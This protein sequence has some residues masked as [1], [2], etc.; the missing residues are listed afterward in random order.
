M[1]APISFEFR[2]IQAL[3]PHTVNQIAAGEVVER[4]ASALKE[5]LENAIDAGSTRIEIELIDAGRTRIRV[6]DN[7]SGIP[8]EDL[9]LALQRHA[10]SKIRSVTDLSRVGTLGFRGEALPSIASVS[11]LT[12]RSGTDGSV[13]AG[14][15][16]E[17][18]TITPL[19][20]EPGPM[21]TEV[22]VEELF[23]N[24]PARLKFLR[25]DATELSLCVEM[26]Q[27]LA[28]AYPGVA[29]RLEHNGSELVRTMGEG[30]VLEALAS[31][32]GRELVRGLAEIDHFENGVR[33]R[34][35]VSPPHLTRSN[36][37]MQ[38]FFVN[39]RATRTR[40]IGTAL[41]VAFRLITPERRFPVAALFLDV[42]PARVD[43]NVSPTK[44]EV[45]FQHEV[46]VT[47]AVRHGIR[48]ALLRCGMNPDAGA[49]LKANEALQRETP[50]N[51]PMLTLFGLAR[52]PVG[53][54]GW[55]NSAPLPHPPPLEPNL[56]GDSPTAIPTGGRAYE[57][58]LEGLRIIGQSMNTFI[59]AE[60]HQGLLVVDQHVA[61]ER[62]LY[63]RFRRSLGRVP[64]ERQAL[65]MPETLHFESRQAV[66]LEEHREE[67]A[68]LG[69]ELDPFGAGSFLL[70]SAPAALRGRDPVKILRE[71]VEQMVEGGSGCV[72]PARDAV[73]IMAACK[74]AVKAGDPLSH[75]EMEKLLLDLGETENPYLCPHGRPITL[76]L[77][78]GDL[79]RR[80]KRH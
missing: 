12:L 49:I 2:R 57:S 19:L 61:H 14:V 54:E 79:E 56:D 22:L 4:P 74:M 51:D 47:D 59:I 30:N 33:V 10:T 64:V 55:T 20:P 21:G 23:Y 8:A 11:R 66:L 58:L 7:G 73:W 15:Q 60:N 77:G 5:L 76:V 48:E 71:V 37:S 70:R 45:K 78:R 32:W 44:M 34:G 3:D 25:S 13:R 6:R 39:Q 36:R 38:W 42:D 53:S 62:I 75:A 16:V 29:V 17:S 1:A 72:A 40:S 46:Q 50:A 27:R 43:C 68:Q 31:I 28:L 52:G 65:L 67:L 26:V 41:D 9:A 63:E 69:F 80:F 18:G 24:T 35:F